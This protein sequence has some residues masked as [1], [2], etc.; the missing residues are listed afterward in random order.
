[1]TAA[2][3]APVT[4]QAWVNAVAAAG[5]APPPTARATPPIAVTVTGP[6]KPLAVGKVA[7]FVIE[8]KNT[9]SVALQNLKVVDRCDAALDSDLGHGRLG[10][11]RRSVGVDH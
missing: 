1:M 11:R 5:A 7:E 9:G 10:R 6:T 4:A 3:V 8:V 2:N